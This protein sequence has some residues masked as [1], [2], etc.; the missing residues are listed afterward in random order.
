MPNPPDAV[1]RNGPAP[2]LGTPVILLPPCR[3]D[4]IA[5]SWSSTRSPG[6]C[7]TPPSPSSR[8]RCRPTSPSRWPRPRSGATRA[9]SRRRPWTT[10]ST[11]SWC[12]AATGR[13]TRLV[14]ALAGTD[15]ALG[16]LPGGATNIL[17]AGAGAADR[18]GRGT[19]V[20]IP[21]ALDDEAFKLNLGRADG[22][23][24]AVN[25]G[26]GV[27]AAAMLRLDKSVPHDQV[28]LRAR[29]I[30][31]G[32]ARAARG[33]R[34]QATRPRPQDRRR[35][36]HAR[37]LGDGRAD[38]PVHVLQGV[39]PADDARGLARDG[40]GRPRRSASSTAGRCHGSRGR[41]SAR[42]ATCTAVTSTTRTTRRTSS[43][44]PRT[45]SPCR[46][47]GTRSATTRLEVRLALEALWVVA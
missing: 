40:P 3:C 47:T 2:E 36:A 28:A 33:L 10:A 41:C 19:G 21:K 25:C 9:S 43:S 26:A 31:G 22:R 15:M 5:C 32:G 27:D 45:R 4:S 37:A 34:R 1:G 16:V 20:L 13:S 46:S 39:R 17:V 6:R 23:Y 18:P 30:P 29:G 24:F 11:W 42:P 38:R 35:R 7:P 44:R 12:S 14:N 8:R